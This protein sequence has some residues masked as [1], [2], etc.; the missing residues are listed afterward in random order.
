MSTSKMTYKDYIFAIIGFLGS[1]LYS[2][3]TL[4]RYAIY[5]ASVV[6]PSLRHPFEMQLVYL[7]DFILS[8]IVLILFI[9]MIILS[10][11]NNEIKSMKYKYGIMMPYSIVGI[12]MFAKI[13]YEGCCSYVNILND[14]SL[15]YLT[16]D[17]Y[18]YYL[19]EITTHIIVLLFTILILVYFIL[20]FYRCIYSII[21]NNSIIEP[22]K[23]S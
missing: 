17:G 5:R 8:C 2:A 10:V 19:Q 4:M 15:Y 18:N 13:N 23:R 14:N 22:K 16:H 12:I 6:H 11:Y 3:F 9:L 21:T 7:K 20:I 1:L